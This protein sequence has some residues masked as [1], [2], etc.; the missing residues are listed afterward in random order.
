MKFHS[1]ASNYLGSFRVFVCNLE[2][3]R[4]CC[5]MS[6]QQGTTG[7]GSPLYGLVYHS[8]LQGGIGRCRRLWWVLDGVGRSEPS[9]HVPEHNGRK[10][11]PCV[12]D[13]T[14]RRPG[15]ACFA[16][17]PH[18]VRFALGALVQQMTVWYWNR[19]QV[20]WIHYCG[21]SRR[22][23]RGLVPAEISCMTPMA[24][25]PL[26]NLVLLWRLSLVSCLVFP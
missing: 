23:P 11:C 12:H 3:S 20:W 2:Y 24:R 15:L 6:W 13:S 26:S 1:T 17:V 16:N 5:R 14:V 10:S 21:M 19:L 25:M 8:E 22:S 7:R 9:K 4:M 18:I